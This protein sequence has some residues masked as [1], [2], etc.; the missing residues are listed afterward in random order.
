MC[1]EPEEEPSWE[2]EPVLKTKLPTP[3]RLAPSPLPLYPRASLMQLLRPSVK[4]LCSLV[5]G[6]HAPA[7]GCE[8]G[9]F[10]AVLDILKTH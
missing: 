8:E 10:D 7:C 6:C 2:L 9:K 3:P 1:S 5:P 4:S